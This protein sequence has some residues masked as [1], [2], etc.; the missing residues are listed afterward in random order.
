[1]LT[2]YSFTGPWWVPAVRGAMA[3][4]FGML[5][6]TLTVRTLDGVVLAF[7]L[8]VLA[9]GLFS[10]AA[11]I[12]SRS[13]TRD[14]W[15]LLLQGVLGLGVGVATLAYPIFTAV[16]L[17]WYVAAWAIVLGGLQIYGAIRLRHAISFEGWLVLSGIVSTAFGIFLLARP[18]HGTIA[19]LWVIGAYSLIW[20][21]VLLV[22]GLSIRTRVPRAPLADTGVS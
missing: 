13:G 14:W 20:G 19:A 8:Y 1:M 9:D 6:L 3:L 12:A 15:I 17:L 5:A 11:S 2:I 18:V 21:V 22:A 7:G 10:I 16:V 4:V